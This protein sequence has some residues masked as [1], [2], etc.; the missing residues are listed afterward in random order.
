MEEIIK[1]L[2][3]D[4]SNGNTKCFVIGWMDKNTTV[5]TVVSGN[6]ETKA[7]ILKQLDVLLSKDILENMNTG[8]DERGDK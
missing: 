3:D 1:K 2:V 5:C 4:I 8:L 7:Y 6:I